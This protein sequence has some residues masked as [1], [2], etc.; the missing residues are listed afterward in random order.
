MKQPCCFI[1]IRSIQVP[2]DKHSSR[3]SSTNLAQLPFNVFTLSSRFI[4]GNYYSTDAL[5]TAPL[6]LE[7]IGVPPIQIHDFIAQPSLLHGFFEVCE[8]R[9]EDVVVAITTADQTCQH[10]DSFRERSAGGEETQAR[11]T[12]RTHSV[13]ESSNRVQSSAR[14]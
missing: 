9:E 12:I 1:R 6:H 11:M 2:T 7:F 3:V 5:G 8:R 13:S 14:A 4:D 10:F